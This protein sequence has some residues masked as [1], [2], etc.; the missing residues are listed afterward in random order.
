MVF[1]ANNQTGPYDASARLGSVVSAPY[2]FWN[3]RAAGALALDL[4]GS[5]TVAVTPTAATPATPDPLCPAISGNL[6]AQDG[7]AKTG[8]VRGPASPEVVALAASARA[9]AWRGDGDEAFAVLAATAD[10]AA[11]DDDRAA[12]FEA[13]AEVFAAV[14]PSDYPEAFVEGLT[15]DAASDAQA[16]PWAARALVVAY[17]EQ[18]R[19]AEA[20]ALAD[21]LSARS[22]PEHATAGHA[23]GV[24][25]AVDAGDAG[26]RH[27][28]AG[29]VR[30][31]RR[32]LG[33]RGRLQSDAFRRGDDLPRGGPVGP[34][35]AGC[36][37]LG[38]G[39]RRQ[40]PDRRSLGLRTRAPPAQTRSTCGP[41]RPLGRR[42][43][44]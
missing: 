8:N 5:S 14:P 31:G 28:A 7:A 6:T 37:A 1:N 35:G 26:R 24:R 34:A 2:A 39:R 43:R 21:A 10:V 29:R 25:L 13:A 44:A 9:A 38:C 23:L 3:G 22:E 41:T 32:R 27:G 36:R 19:A 4:D 20:A 12:V 33:V 30:H 16:A 18:G 15:D 42:R 17:A 40:K 11:T